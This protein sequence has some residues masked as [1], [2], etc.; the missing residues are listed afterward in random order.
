MTFTPLATDPAPKQPRD[1]TVD[2]VADVPNWFTGMSPHNSDSSSFWPQKDLAISWYPGEATHAGG[3]FSLFSQY[4]RDHEGNYAGFAHA[5]H[6]VIRS[7]YGE[8]L[9]VDEWIWW[10]RAVQAHCQWTPSL[11]VIQTLMAKVVAD[12][13]D[14]T[15]LGPESA[16]VDEPN[17]PTAR[18]LTRIA[19]AALFDHLAACLVVGETPVT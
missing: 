17:H 10:H 8:R 4:G 19:A 15:M 1:L 6:C 11:A 13:I 9:T 7:E 5:D 16:D 3:T 2:D 12:R 14:K 18:A